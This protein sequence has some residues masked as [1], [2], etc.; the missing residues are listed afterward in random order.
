MKSKHHE[1]FITHVLPFILIGIIALVPLLTRDPY[2]LHILVLG[3]IYVIL[4]IGMNIITGYCGQINLGMAGF[5][6]V[7]AYTSALLTSRLSLSFWL[8][9]PISALVAGIAGVLVG[10]PALKVRGGVYLVLITTSFAGIVQVILNQWVSLTKGPMGIVGIPAPAIGNVLIYERIHWFYLTYAIVAVIV[11]LAI[12]LVGSRIGRSF[13]ALRESETSA[14]S[15]GISPA[16]YKVLAFVC[17]AV[18]AGIAGSIYAHY[19]TT[20]SPDAFGFNLSVLALIM[21]VVGGIGSIPGSIVGGVTMALFPEWLR[22]LG[23]YQ[24]VAYAVGIIL[25][26]VFLPKG[27]LM[28]GVDA[29]QLIRKWFLAPDETSEKEVS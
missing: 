17:S 10:V 1:N 8:A 23:P 28:M 24:S 14:Q 11:F 7:G 15:I 5:F 29:V 18:L 25:A 12:R 27:L 21:I 4:A 26:V 3:G 13:V 19:M 20:I 2:L 9:L 22:A 6:A 16:F